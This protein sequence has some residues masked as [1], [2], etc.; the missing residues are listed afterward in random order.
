MDD[1]TA[2][3]DDGAIATKN[4]THH[5]GPAL[6]SN[7]WI[8]ELADQEIRIR[9]LDFLTKHFLILSSALLGISSALSLLFCPRTWRCSIG[10]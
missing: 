7:E 5:D 6:G 9:A 10:R 1:S 3:R 4:A 8:T 2:I